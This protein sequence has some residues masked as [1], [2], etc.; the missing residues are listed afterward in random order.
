MNCPPLFAR[1]LAFRELASYA[2]KRGLG[3][4]Q[5][6]EPVLVRLLWRRLPLHKFRNAEIRALIDWMVEHRPRASRR[7]D[8]GSAEALRKRA[9]R[10]AG[11]IA[12]ATLD[13]A[14]VSQ[15]SLKDG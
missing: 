2:E 12:P 14:W 4:A 7:G 6:Y 9:E 8:V 11:K 15:E 13:A 5:V 1:A 10:R 3:V